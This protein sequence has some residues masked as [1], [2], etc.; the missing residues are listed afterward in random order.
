MPK[1]LVGCAKETFRTPTL[2]VGVMLAPVRRPSDNQTLRSRLEATPTG[3]EKSTP[4]I[5]HPAPGNRSPR[6]S[7]TIRCCSPSSS[8]KR[9]A[10]S[11]TQRAPTRR[12]SLLPRVT[13]AFRHERSDPAVFREMGA[14]GL[15][16]STLPA[17]FGGAGLNYVCYGLIAR[18]IERVDSGYRS[19][20]SVQS[21]LVMHPISRLWLGCA[22]QPISAEARER[23]VDRLLRTD[24]A[25]SRLG[26]RLDGDPGA[27][28]A[29]RVQAFGRQDL[30]FEFADRRRVRRLG[31]DRRRRDSRLHPREGNARTIGAENRR[32]VQ[33]AHVDHRRGS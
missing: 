2:R 23:R 5:A 11:A 19:M 28:G 18:E 26:S 27:V 21:S 1:P 8:R 10:W 3:V 9:S 22:A 31:Q 7:G 20:M 16:G 12:I 32:Q 6:S 15:L 25:E 4:Q 33:P 29:R 17:E 30:D 13:D 24:R 14:L